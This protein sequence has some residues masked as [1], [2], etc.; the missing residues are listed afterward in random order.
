METT[1][2]IKKTKSDGIIHFLFTKDREKIKIST[3]RKIKNSKWGG[4]FP[5]QINSTSELRRDLS[6]WKRELD[7][8][9]K[10]KIRVEHR[11]PTRAELKDECSMIINGINHDEQTINL[12]TLVGEMIE[13][14]C[15]ELTSGTIRYK[16]I[17]LRH[18]IQFVGSHRTTL[19]LNEDILLRYRRILIGER[20]ENVTTNC[21][22][23]SLRSFLNWL[24]IK[25]RISHQLS[26]C[27][28]NL[29]EVEKDG[30]VLNEN[31]MEILETS[32]LPK[33][34][35]NQVDIFLFGCYTA[36]SIS[37]MMRVKREMII[38]NTIV[39][40]RNKT[41]GLLRIPL[42]NESKR[43]L[44]KYNYKLPFIH[45]NKGSQNLKKAFEI[46]GIDRKVRIT[47]KYFDRQATDSYVPLYKVI[48]WHKSRKT[49]ITTAINK[50][51]PHVT[52][53][54]LSGHRKFETFMK[55]VELANRD[56]EREM[57][58]LSRA[59]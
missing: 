6:N 53:M 14:Q 48:S 20:R 25:K 15:L 4:G 45:K 49:A 47:K 12:K 5:K 22:L 57:N 52:V 46:L 51:I 10:E 2:F 18:F 21:Y 35:Q 43:I 9:I 13:E 37:D 7:H 27:L 58:K 26:T 39:M 41:E 40:R 11:K 36:L 33:H 32:N 50:G 16:K 54:Q 19:D 28:K 24:W 1:Y 44:E 31:E 30:V 8:F 55:Y 17:H 42:I 23:K 56:L 59:K 29:N 38:D 3:K 34:L